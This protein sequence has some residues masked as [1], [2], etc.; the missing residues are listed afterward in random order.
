MNKDLFM[1]KAM[2]EAQKEEI[3]RG[4]PITHIYIVGD[5]YFFDQESVEGMR[6]DHVLIKN[7][8]RTSFQNYFRS[9]RRRERNQKHLEV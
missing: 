5:Q 3:R 7:D 1:K 9:K 6:V 2:E 8:L 4:R